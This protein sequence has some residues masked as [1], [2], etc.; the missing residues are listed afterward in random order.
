MAS[1][2]SSRA[3]TQPLRRTTRIHSQKS[4]H[5]TWHRAPNSNPTASSAPTPVVPDGSHPAETPRKPSYKLPAYWSLAPTVPSPFAGTLE[6]SLDAILAWGQ[7]W[8]GGNTEDPV[9]SIVTT[10]LGKVD[11]G[12][13]WPVLLRSLFLAGPDAAG[14]RGRRVVEELLVLGTRTLLPEQIVENR[15]AMARVYG[16]RKHLAIR[17]MLR[18]DMMRE[19]KVGGSGRQHAVVVN[20]VAPGGEGRA[21][22]GME[23]GEAQKQQK[24]QQLEAK[25]H[26]QAQSQPQPQARLRTQETSLH[27]RPLMPNIWPTLILPPPHLLTNAYPTHGYRERMRHH[28]TD[29]DP[30]L[31]YADDEVHSWGDAMLI[32]RTATVLLMWQ[33]VRGNNE[34]LADM[35]VEGWEVLDGKAEECVWVA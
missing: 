21:V 15:G 30:L 22:P 17:L 4:S 5:A 2:P 14:G 10:L 28:V 3:S 33:W 7:Q 29:L 31:L 32:A 16:E 20:S 27:R 24:Q 9:R 34:V 19:G 12:T 35:E 8:S 18:Y 6:A 25:S 13:N 1:Q 26:H 23:R 11:S